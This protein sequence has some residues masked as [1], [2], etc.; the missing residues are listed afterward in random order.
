MFGHNV[1]LPALIDNRVETY[2]LL[3]TGAW[4]TV[5]SKRLGDRL[6]RLRESNV[7]IR[8]VSGE[9]RAVEEI[10]GDTLLIFPGVQQEHR[11]VKVL[12]LDHIGRSG[13][14][15]GGV[16]GYSLLQYM[17]LTLDGRRGLVRMVPGK[18][19]RRPSR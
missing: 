17:E 6:G 16:I 8:G 13:A 2:F 14:G 18:V 9:T 19:R 11:N 3:D 15:I 10:H 12:D 7:V 1:I 4:A 5:L